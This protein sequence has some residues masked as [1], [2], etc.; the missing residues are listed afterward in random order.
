[1]SRELRVSLPSTI[2][3]VSGS[4]NGKDYTWTLDG[5]AWKATVD[6]SADEKYFVSLTAI[7]AA[8]TSTNFELSLNYGLLSLITDRTQADV[9]AV[10]AALGRIEA[11]RGTAADLQLLD[12]N[13]GS[14]NYT[15]L[16]RV[17]GAVLYV[18]EE[19]S[20]NGYKVAVDGKQ[21]WTENDIPTQG[22]IDKYLADIEAIR[23]ALPLPKNAPV[24]PGMPLDYK[25]ANDIESIL[26]L[27]DKLIQN[28]SKSWFY[29]GEL[30]SNEFSK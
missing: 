21:G 1:M 8:G 12:S 28:I 9:D 26:L 17:A 16:N 11:G 14:Y 22:D 27:V 30:Y 7:N 25:K 6:R 5:D 29:S 18:A 2:V 20:D 15:D 10:N 24:T 4:V 19:L 23:S 13:K 3:Y